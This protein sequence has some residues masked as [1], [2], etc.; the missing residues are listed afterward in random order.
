MAHNHCDRPEAHALER[1]AEELALLRL[2]VQHLSHA[3]DQSKQEKQK[4]EAALATVEANKAK[5]EK[6]QVLEQF[7]HY[8]A[9]RASFGTAEIKNPPTHTSGDAPAGSAPEQKLTPRKR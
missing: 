9:G 7:E 5:L 8:P 2:A 3:F 1:I 6:L 4:L